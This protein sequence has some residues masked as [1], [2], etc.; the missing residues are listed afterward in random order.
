MGMRDADF[1]GSVANSWLPWV[2][3]IEECRFGAPD[4]RRD[5]GQKIEIS[6]MSD[7]NIS[8][9]RR[10]YRRTSNR[11]TSKTKNRTKAMKPTGMV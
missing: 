5:K 3:W 10:N 9:T 1:S 2:L 7:L 4:G 6:A 11:I 8:L